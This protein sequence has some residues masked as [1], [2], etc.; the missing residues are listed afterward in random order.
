MKAAVRRA[1]VVDYARMCELFGQGDALH[2]GALPHLFRQTQGPSRD[3]EFIERV[4]SDADALLLVAEHAGQLVGV[5]RAAVRQAPGHPPV[6]PRSFV[7]VSELVVR[8]GFRGQ[9][10]GTLLMEAAHRWAA[11]KGAGTVELTVW[12]FN[13]EALA[14]YE[15]LGYTTMYRRL[16]RAV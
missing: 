9:G 11:E 15:K 5:L 7:E 14:L 4:L 6:V 2:A 3:Q 16:S 12:D 1:G 13:T 8:E 10:I